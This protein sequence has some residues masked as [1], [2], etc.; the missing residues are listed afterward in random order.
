MMGRLASLFRDF[1]HTFTSKPSINSRF[2]LVKE[3]DQRLDH[4]LD[5][6]PLLRPVADESIF[7]QYPVNGRFDWTPWARFVWATTIPAM[8][9]QLWRWHLSRSYTDPRFAEAREVC[10]GA[11]R[12]MLATRLKPVPIM[13]QK[14]WHVSSHTVICG[15]VL[16]IEMAHGAPDPTTRQRLRS[17][18]LETLGV[19]QSTANPNAMVKR[20]IQILE[21]ML[22]DAD[23]AAAALADFSWPGGDFD[24]DVF[25]MILNSDAYV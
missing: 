12:T 13:F 17:D 18:V 6:T 21:K 19:L 9:I 22:N 5:D 2:R 11:A 4:L 24:L 15:M 7:P 20:G 3:F 23:Q 14:N 10:I 16:A 1:C 25:D 8:R